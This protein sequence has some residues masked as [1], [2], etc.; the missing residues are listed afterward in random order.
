MRYAVI[1]FWLFST[2]VLVPAV[3]G[4]APPAVGQFHIYKRV[5]LPLTRDVEPAYAA[6]N[7]FCTAYMLEMARRS[8]SDKPAGW[9][10][11]VVLRP[12]PKNQ[13]RPHI[14]V[15]GHSGGRTVRIADLE[16]TPQLTTRL[17]AARTA[18]KSIQT[19]LDPS[20]NRLARS[21]PR[22]EAALASHKR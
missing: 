5:G 19:L 15:V 17:A 4:Q 3:N 10:F 11:W 22:P 20:Y 6:F 7:G 14:L 21:R 18:Q 12:D 16:A 13:N 2:A 9:D 1:G 8:N